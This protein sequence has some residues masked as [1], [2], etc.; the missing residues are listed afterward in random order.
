MSCGRNVLASEACPPFSSGGDDDR[1]IE[2]PLFNP[3]PSGRRVPPLYAQSAKQLQLSAAFV[4]RENTL[5]QLKSVFRRKESK[6]LKAKAK[7][8]RK[9]PS[10][11]RT[12]EIIRDLD[13][14][15]YAPSQRTQNFR[16]KQREVSRRQN[17]DRKQSKLQAGMPD[18]VSGTI[19][20]LLKRVGQKS[21]I[22][23][24]IIESVT[25]LVYQ[26]IHASTGTAR[27]VAIASFVKHIYK[28]SLIVGTI[29]G[30]KILNE[31]IDECIDH[32]QSDQESPFAAVRNFLTSYE[33]VKKSKIYLKLYKFAMYALSLSMFDK[34]GVT[35]DS[36]QFEVLEAES[37]RKRHHMGADFVFTMLDTIVFL[38]ER[39]HQFLKTGRMDSILHS[40][41]AYEQWFEDASQLL[42]DVKFISNA[43][44]HGIDE[45]EV[46]SRL[47]ELLDKGKCIFVHAKR[48]DATEKRYIERVLGDLKI[49]ERTLIGTAFNQK[50]RRSPFSLLVSG[51]SSVMKTAF[52]NVLHMQYAKLFGLQIGTEYRYS[53]DS[54]P[55][56]WDDF[57]T[58][59]WF[60][61]LDDVAF[62]KPQVV[63]GM[64]PSTEMVIKVVNNTTF[65]PDQ[66]K[67]E[68]KGVVVCKPR[69]VVAT[70]NTEHL[71]ADFFFACPLAI[72]RRF[73]FTI[74]VQPKP[75][76][77]V[78]GVFMNSAV[79]GPVARGEYLDLWKITVKRTVPAN[80]SLVDQ[81][82]KLVVIKEY[83][84]I[85]K[86]LMWFNEVA[87]AHERI[88][89]SSDDA[90]VSMSSA[91][92]CPVC[93]VPV[94]QCSDGVH[95]T[96][97][98]VGA[99][100]SKEELEDDSNLMLDLAHYDSTEPPDVRCERMKGL[101]DRLTAR[102]VRARER[103]RVAM[104]ENQETEEKTEFEK[105]A[106]Y[107]VKAKAFVAEMNR[108]REK[109]EEEMWYHRWYTYVIWCFF[110]PFIQCYMYSS[111]F[112]KYANW[113]YMTP[114]VLGFFWR[115][116]N[117]RVNE[118]RV[119]K[120]IFRGLGE[121]NAVLIGRVPTVV[122]LGVA[123]GSMLLV[124]KVVS[125]SIRYMF[126]ET[127]SAVL[128]C[129]Q[130]P[131][132]PCYVEKGRLQG[133]VLSTGRPPEAMISEVHNVWHNKEL[134]VC[135]MDIS[136]L[137]SSWKSL[138]KEQVHQKVL[139]NCVFF[140]FT[141]WQGEKQMEQFNRGFC[142]GGNIYVTNA[143]ALPSRLISTNSDGVETRE[144]FES[145]TVEMTVQ[146]T[147]AGVTANNKCN[148]RRSMLYI[149]ESRDLVAMQLFSIPL[150]PS[151]LE[152][153]ALD[154]FD[155]ACEGVLLKRDQTGL[156]SVN[157][158]SAI[159]RL[160]VQSELGVF[161][162]WE[163]SAMRPTVHGDCGAVM[164]GYAPRGPVIL[165]FH[166]MGGFA[167]SVRR[168]VSV[169]VTQS[170][171][172]KAIAYFPIP[173]IV[174]NFPVLSTA[175]VKREVIGLNA[176]S[177]I[178]FL[179]EGTGTVYG[180][181][182]GARANHKSYVVPTVLKPA[183][184]KR[185]LLDHKF[186]PPEM[187]GKGWWKKWFRS[188][189]GI[190]DPV[191]DF[192]PKVMQEC[193]QTYLDDVLAGLS[194]EDLN[195]LHVVDLDT[196]INGADG[197]GY[198]DRLNMS[199]GAGFPMS[200]PKKKYMVS[201]NDPLHPDRVVPTTE[202]M[203]MLDVAIS[204]LEKGETMGAV[205]KGSPKDEA[206]KW[207]KVNDGAIR[208]FLGGSVVHTILLR[209]YF[210]MLMRLMKRKRFLF[211]QM[212]G[213]RAQCG[214]WA[215]LSEYLTQ[216]NKDRLLAGDY[217]L[218]DKRM[219][220]YVIL[221]SFWVFI[222]ILERAGYS[223]AELTVCWSLAFDVAFPTLDHAGD[224][225]QA[226]GS[227][228]SG[229]G[230][231]VEVNGTGG[232]IYGRY[233]YSIAKSRFFREEYAAFKTQ[234]VELK[235]WL[236]S[237]NA[238]YLAGEVPSADFKRF[239]ALATYGDDNAANVHKAAVWF[240]HTSMQR[241]LGDIGIK[242][243]MADKEAESVPYISIDEVSFLK[244]KF[245]FDEIMGV[246]LAPLEESSI[247]KML[248]WCVAS[249][250]V[251]EKEQALSIIESAGREYFQYGKGIFESKQTMLKEIVEESGLGLFVKPST[252][253]PWSVLE[254]EYRNSTRFTE[255]FRPAGSALFV[256][257]S[258]ETH[259]NM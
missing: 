10:A 234:D 192:D 150:K 13:W 142:V 102:N 212:P 236:E 29:N 85:Y 154:T 27:A 222:K 180:S 140:R 54:V 255:P 120:A 245:E 79:V 68:N 259:L 229:Q 173:S 145:F 151:L 258:L 62:M 247:T 225:V 18:V 176:K 20:E 201:A 93:R 121:K 177:A 206:I 141:W 131:D 218:F 31:L 37:I 210:V 208:I 16:A 214:D 28:G 98:I 14:A 207:K 202:L 244:R 186:G 115:Y 17:R 184:E 38:C 164:L 193:A 190:L 2:L 213:V 40:G 240:S 52:V 160:K 153:F 199:S 46:R 167:V 163:A 48:M 100:E 50:T 147:R 23:L 39:G 178:R 175:T 231:T 198:V 197:V 91:V 161:D 143:H 203:E 126:S 253:L 157:N 118:T 6:L 191:T 117:Q 111:F 211:E 57:K 25:I 238:A 87:E 35:F 226:H 237:I 9:L 224:L 69:F 51:G 55:K 243:T 105:L 155:T 76:Y 24:D 53:V 209:K 250:S 116:L 205:F 12:E 61:L 235:M 221:L 132:C 36:C 119:V 41:S 248:S 179:P 107:R 239:V 162:A 128:V 251:S 152:L 26:V 227:N 89:D 83:M 188:A 34:I 56:F 60:L 95:Q 8:L 182:T 146:E 77:L 84:S 44:A 97:P 30:G 5:I 195:Q 181:L 133:S 88:Q 223:E 232:C 64:D 230:M 22:I 59:M 86:F 75:E 252:F 183:L 122:A 7:E 148:V 32:F 70:T 71:N 216:F 134:Q 90:I 74:N 136:P 241:D 257:S 104:Q 138:L 194:Q 45:F 189:E 123:A 43:E 196:A 220:A 94:C 80:D 58:Q 156:A 125:K 11:L 233:A 108:E 242:Y 66:A 78:D 254:T 256:E 109:I 137:S 165:G 166:F 127:T 171:L 67:L 99:D 174:P 73:P 217:A 187:G 33:E 172:R 215:A 19:Q 114:W 72:R 42:L 47:S 110:F 228:P 130:G 158:L 124:Y 159:R 144:W 129:E 170:D 96:S 21:E 81:K 49:A 139:K 82:A 246:V 92:L 4:A 149:D 65:I 185:G 169:R 63:Q 168:V 113:S 204:K 15:D 135:A 3:L 103:M 200:G 1:S 101:R 106:D 249:K 219:P 112:R